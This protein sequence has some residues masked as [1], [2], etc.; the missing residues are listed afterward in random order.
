[1]TPTEFCI[2]LGASA[3]SGACAGVYY[4]SS[5]IGLAVYFALLAITYK[6]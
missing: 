4:S 5:F 3:M 1:M 6:E 2:R